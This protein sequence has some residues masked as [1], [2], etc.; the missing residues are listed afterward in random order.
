[1]TQTFSQESISI[2]I[3]DDVRLLREGLVSLLGEQQEIIIVGAAA[4]GSTALEQIIELRPD[5]ALVDIGLPGKD[6][7]SVTQALRRES[8]EVKVLILGI[9]DFADEIMACIE[10]GA[11]GYVLKEASF[12]HLVDSIRAIHHGESLC[13][14][15][16]V[17][18]L[19]SRVAEM[20]SEHPPSVIQNSLKLTSRELEIINE[21]ADGLSNKEIARRLVIEPQTVKNHIHNILDKLQLHSRLEAVAYARDRNLLRDSHP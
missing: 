19:F 15:R 12:D 10:A 7:L 4:S 14:P 13:S 21:I 2:F 3:V 18:S 5:V 17:A 6:G 20:A 11:A 9:S 16:I 8:P 1:M